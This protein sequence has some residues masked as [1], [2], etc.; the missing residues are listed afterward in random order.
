MFAKPLS[1]HPVGHRDDLAGAAAAAA[2]R[3]DGAGGHDLAA[4]AVQHRAQPGELARGHVR[5][6]WAGGKSGAW[7][8]EVF[9]ERERERER[10]RKDKRRERE[11]ERE[12]VTARDKI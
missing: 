5:A 4:A 9:I 1:L 12:S 2:V 8:I 6:D 10:Y 7:K 11:R 3:D